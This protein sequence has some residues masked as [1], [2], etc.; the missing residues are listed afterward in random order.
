LTAYACTLAVSADPTSS[1][2]ARPL[3][4]WSTHDA[5]VRWAPAS[6]PTITGTS[7][8]VTPARDRSHRVTLS[9]TDDA[10]DQNAQACAHSQYFLSEDD[11]ATWRRI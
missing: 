8:D 7:C 2:S 9:V 6:L 10:L 5:G 3:T 4:V 1:Y 11:G